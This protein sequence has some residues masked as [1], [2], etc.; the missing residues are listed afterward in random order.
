MTPHGKP[1]DS[2][3][4]DECSQWSCLSFYG[5]SFLLSGLLDA[6]VYVRVWGRKPSVEGRDVELLASCWSFRR[7]PGPTMSC[8]GAEMSFIFIASSVLTRCSAQCRH[9]SVEGRYGLWVQRPGQNLRWVSAILGSVVPIHSLCHRPFMSQVQA[10]CKS[11]HATDEE[12]PEI[13]LLPWRSPWSIRKDRSINSVLKGALDR[14][15][16]FETSR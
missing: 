8:L 10:H 2:L 7:P 13:G 12:V 4:K 9:S 6:S 16:T 3:I 5:N 14:S 15:G 11:G 1:P